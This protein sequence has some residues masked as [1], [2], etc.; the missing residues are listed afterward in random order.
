MNGVVHPELVTGRED[1]FANAAWTVR[2]GTTQR[3]EASCNLTER[4][5]EVPLGPDATS[6]VVR[7]HE[8]MHARVSPH[9]LE[10]FGTL[11]EMAPRA[12][13]CAEEF[14]VNTLIGRLDFDTAL[15]RD[16]SEKNGA[17]RIAESGDWSEAICFLM[18]V[19]GTGGEKEFLAGIRQIQPTWMSGLRAVRKC[20]LAMMDGLSSVAL[21]ATRLNEEGLPCGY[22]NATVVLARLLTQSMHARPPCTPEELR[23]FRRSLQPG[24]RRPPTG[25]FAALRIDEAVTMSPRPR[26]AGVRRERASTSGP[27]MRYPS[28]LLTDDLKRAFARRATSHGGIVIIDQSGSMDIDVATLSTVL[29]RAPNALVVGY[30]HRPGDGG[31]TPNLWILAD[32]GAVATKVPSGNIGN[33]VDG[34]VLEWALRRRR[35]TEP[36]V[37]VTDG[38]VTD[39]HD[40]P[41]LRLTTQCA[42]SVR[43]HRI[44][45]VREVGG[46][47]RVLASNRANPRSEL[48]QFGR[49]GRV[50]LEMRAF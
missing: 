37:W 40:H 32:R 13:E 47:G 23:S 33:G 21:G 29:C 28:R 9:V 26:G 42:E 12:L 19:L 24:G 16:G 6:R 35:G 34:A 7:A 41:D 14:R 45:L 46:A 3:G 10:H 20:A 38:Q 36:I 27:S 49:L 31:S 18:A 5:L 30:S 44:R 48:T 43:R 11:D 39:S 2:P 15:L 22:A 17:R 50:L 4:I 8:L 25:R 1:G